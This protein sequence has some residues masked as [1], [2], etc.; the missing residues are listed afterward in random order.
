MNPYTECKV[1]NQGGKEMDY[2][3]PDLV[4]EIQHKVKANKVFDNYKEKVRGKMK[5]EKGDA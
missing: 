4:I 2:M 3:T 1:K 5:E